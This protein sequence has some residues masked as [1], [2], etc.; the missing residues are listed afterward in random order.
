MANDQNRDDPGHDDLVDGATLPLAASSDVSPTLAAGSALAIGIREVAA[1]STAPRG[2]DTAATHDMPIVVRAGRGEEYQELATLDPARYIVDREIA[3]GGMGRIVA[4]RDRR[5]GRSVAIKELLSGAGDLRARFER[6]ARITA[7]LQHPAIVSLLEAGVWPGGEPLY[8]MKLVAGES[9][10][11]VVRE[12][13]TLA[14]RLGLLPHIIAAV[15]A[16]AYAHSLRVIH[17][18]LK[19]A[20]VLVGQFGETVVIDWGLAKDLGDPSNTSDVTLGPNRWAAR[21]PSSAS[22]SGGETVAGS[23]LGTPAYMPPEQALGDPVDERADVYSLGAMLYHVLTGAAPYTGKTAAVILDAVV[24]GPPPPVASRTP[25]VPRDLV[26][27]MNKAMAHAAVDRYPTAKELSEDLKKF[28]TGQLV[29]AHDYTA[30]QLAGRW[31]RRHRTAV[32]VASV[33]VVL[34]AVVATVSLRRIIGEQA[35]TEQQRQ[36]A[37]RSRGDAEDLT[38]FMLGDL[39]AKLQPLGKLDLLDDVA[40]KAVAYYDGRGSDLSDAELGKLALARRN[41]GDVLRVQKDGD[42]PGALVQ[43]RGSLAITRALAAKA[44]GD[45]ERQRDLAESHDKVADV[46]SA[47]GDSVGALAEYREA[48]AI[49]EALAAKDPAKAELQADLWFSHHRI[50]NVLFAQGDA[51][52]ALAEYR[53]M[54]A[55]AQS[56]AAKDPANAAWQSNVSESDNKVGDVVLAHGDPA[57]ALAAYR[58]SLAITQS[59]AD[60]DPTNADREHDLAYSHNRVG[61]VLYAQRDWPKALSEYRASLILC[62]ALA[63][64]DPT[65][66]DRQR[67]LS[68]AHNKVGNVLAAQGDV[69]HAL[70]EYRADLE[71]AETLAARDVTNSERQADLSVSHN[72]VGNVL[73]GKGDASGALAEYRAS[74]AITDALVAKDPTNADRQRAVSVAHN[75]IGD[76]RATLG[77]RDGALVDYHAAA[78][79]IATLS[80]KDPTNAE[81][82]VD[83]AVSHQRIGDVE[84]AQGDKAAALQDFKAG[85]AVMQTLLAKEPTNADA[86]EVI[87][88]L[89]KE[90]ATCCAKK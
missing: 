10:D 52:G 39:R 55:I 9:L 75:K 38:S 89:T 51:P 21:D 69:T 64:K 41:L 76:A 45:V 83:V 29:G 2:D 26:T 7:K 81:L 36:V 43:Y 17:R 66:A 31:I 85:I 72:K 23:I 24:A 42:L 30:W 58:A 6:E 80:E 86:H 82:Q 15:D 1:G 22:G 77:D 3:R 27:I 62:E 40:K 57:E 32:A 90:S 20:N 37:E 35:R 12:R 84:L 60:K 59:L 13:P 65:N 53:T 46:V 63:N 71:I 56:V 28:Q 5:L 8:I 50:G 73:L 54:L 68:V 14:A 74:L 61:N 87:D 19:P 78:A 79:I 44:P 34:L 88:A 47:Q 4:A 49:R 16:L 11:H 48:R 70:A 33:A 18:D 25:G 67:A